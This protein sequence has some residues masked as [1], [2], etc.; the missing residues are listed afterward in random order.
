[1]TYGDL[2]RELGASHVAQ[3]SGLGRAATLACDNGAVQ[4]MQETAA[5]YRMAGAMLPQRMDSGVQSLAASYSQYN[6]AQPD[7]AHRRDWNFIYQSVGG[8]GSLFPGGI[9]NP[10][11][12]IAVCFQSAYARALAGGQ[13]PAPRPRPQPPT[14]PAPPTKPIPT[15]EPAPPTKPITPEPPPVSIP[16]EP[17]PQPPPTDPIR[18]QPPAPR[19][20]PRPQPAPQPG[21][22]PAPQPTP[23]PAPQPG[24]PNE[25]PAQPFIPGIGTIIGTI[26]GALQDP[27]DPAAW[28]KAPRNT[29]QSDLAAADGNSREAY[30][31]IQQPQ[32]NEGANWAYWDGDSWK[33]AR[34]LSGLCNPADTDIVGAVELVYGSTGGQSVGTSVMIPPQTGVTTMPNVPGLTPVQPIIIQTR[35]CPGPTRLAIDGL[36]YHKSVLPAQL[37]ANRPRKAPVSWSDARSIQRGFAA[38]KRIKRYEKLASKQAKKLAPTTRRRPTTKRK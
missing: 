1:M 9:G 26:G 13:A 12:G 6:R 32:A 23:T 21:P 31:L 33:L 19:P 5:D 38:A 36:C 7:A 4:Q 10:G 18:P 17:T 29:T 28:T 8:S 16:V 2:A 30:G 14:T 34:S 37:R 15:P 20:Q 27:C 22:Q 11:A 24:I 3:P 35:R 25:P